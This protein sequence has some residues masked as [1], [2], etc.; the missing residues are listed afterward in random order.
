LDKAVGRTSAKETSTDETGDSPLHGA[1]FDKDL[2]Q[3]PKVL[4]LS[5][6]LMCMGTALIGGGV[7]ALSMDTTTV[8]HRIPVPSHDRTQAVALAGL[9]SANDTPGG[10]MTGNQAV[11]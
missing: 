11:P 9:H 10:P 3:T 5:V 2:H 4:W 7:V 6:A 8:G 1:A